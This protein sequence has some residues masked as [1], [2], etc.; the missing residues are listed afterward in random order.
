M[1]VGI[2]QLDDC[3]C[4]LLLLCLECH[5]P[6][7]TM[8]CLPVEFSIESPSVY[9]SSVPVSDQYRRTPPARRTIPSIRLNN[10]SGSSCEKPKI[11]STRIAMPTMR[12]SRGSTFPLIACRRSTV[13]VIR[14]PQRISPAR[15][16]A[17]IYKSVSH[18]CFK[19]DIFISS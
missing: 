12:S 6:R 9:Q 13:I 18:S 5:H 14:Y 3:G 8:F 10:P 7:L 2:P 16:P 1:S 15:P 11:G 17:L 4:E 19:F